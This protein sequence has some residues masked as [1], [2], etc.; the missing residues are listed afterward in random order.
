MRK[1][2]T[3]KDR[4]VDILVYTFL[5][6]T[7]FA[8]LAPIL[9]TFALSLSSSAM[10]NSGT[11][12]F[13][14]KQFTIA[15]YR[16]IMKEKQLYRSFLISIERVLIGGNLNFLLTVLTAF[17][18]AHSS[19]E[20]R[21]R[22]FYLW[23]LI[24]CMIF[25]GGLVPLY[26]IVNKL[27]LIDTIWSLTLPGCVPIWNCIL[28]MNF[29]RNLP[30]E[31]EEA[32]LIDGATPWKILLRVFLPVSLP[33]LATVTL[34]SVVGHWNDWFAGSIYM[35]SSSNYPLATYIQTL[36]NS[37]KDI[38]QIKDPEQIKRILETSDTTVNS[39]KIFVSMIPILAVYPFMQRFFI[40]GL[41]VGSIK[42]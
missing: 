6:M 34:F 15:A 17:P 2:N 39:A 9:N 27:G 10:A 40:T 28:L 38:S 1:Y 7:A 18:M 20:F 31:M 5:T 42:E 24:F 36:V 3:V 26:I 29:F 4:I 14:P 41:V 30:K 16:F 13:W 21:A 22:K 35:N 32:A 37:A 33:S 19:K 25:S 8:C 12:T 11:V 23:Y